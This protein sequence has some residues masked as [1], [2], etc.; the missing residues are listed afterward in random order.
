MVSTMQNLT[1]GTLAQCIN[2]LIPIREMVPRDNEIVTALV[3]IPMVIMCIIERGH[4]LPAALAEE[5]DIR[6]LQDLLSLEL[7][8]VLVL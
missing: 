6:I 1:K 5:I 2:N 8:E 4:F 3:I 7:R